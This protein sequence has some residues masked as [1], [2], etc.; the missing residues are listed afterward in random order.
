MDAMDLCYTPATELADLIREKKISPIEVMEALFSRL[1]TVNPEINAYCTLLPEQAM[2]EAGKAEEAVAK[3]EKLGPL[4][5]VPVSIKDLTFTKGVRTTGGSRI[6]EDFIPDEDAIVV[7][8]LKAA[9][10]IVV[11]KTNTPE[12]GWK[13]VTDNPLFGIT[14]NPWDLSKTPGGS[15]GGAG[16]AV[17]AGLGPLAVGGDGGGSIRI[18][19][20]FSGIFGH[21]P[22]FGRV[23]QYPGFPGWETLGHTGPMTRTVRDTALMLDVIAGPH[24]GDRHSLPREQLSYLEETGGG[25]KGLRVAWSQDLG[26]APVDRVVREVTSSA[27]KVFSGLG[28]ELEE[29]DPDIENPERAFGIMVSSD[30]SAKLMDKVDEWGEKMDP[31]LLMF[32]QR[33]QK[34]SAVDLQKANLQRSDFW[35]SI[36]P[37]FQKYDLLLTPTIPV[38]PF[39]VENMGPREI[40]GVSVSPTGWLNFTFPFNFTGQ[41]AANVPAGWTEDGLPIGLQIIG[42]RHDDV[43][44]LRAAAA[45]EEAAPWVQRRPPVDRA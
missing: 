26:Y 39:E 36:L 12:F 14:R 21:K 5:G 28:C 20:S 43:T 3:G 13:G 7:E 1:E 18:P 35:H 19:A 32:I 9:G 40:D 11:G 6:Y 31:M 24:D 17:A 23:P 37:F 42:R 25:I 16:A 8:R 41:P 4:H 2:E 38:P 44:V 34:Y 15:S 27:V 45:F 30:T 10:A 22:S 33:G 29:A